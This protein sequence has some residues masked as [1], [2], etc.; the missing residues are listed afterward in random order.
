MPILTV[1][2][3]GVLVVA[4]VQESVFAVCL[5]CIAYRFLWEC[6]DCDDISERLRAAMQTK[7][8]AAATS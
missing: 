2:L 4:A 6:D 1:V 7:L 5:G 3:V 8:D